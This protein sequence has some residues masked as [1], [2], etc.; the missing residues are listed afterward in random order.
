MLNKKKNNKGFTLVE[1]LVVIAI[2]GILAVVAVPALFKN[3]EK[4]KIADL[5]ADISAIRS[6]AL[7]VYA[8]TSEMPTGAIYA[9]GSVQASSKIGA[10]LEGLSNPFGGT[11]TTELKNNNNTLV[12][13]IDVTKGISKDGSKKLASDLGDKYVTADLKQISPESAQ[14]ISSNTSVYVK[15]MEK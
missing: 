5:E 2:I 8:D 1:L 15:L 13:K 10:E 14:P 4:G 12:L 11:Y 3:I 9:N 7:S 6:A